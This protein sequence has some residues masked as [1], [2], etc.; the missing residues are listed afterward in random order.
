MKTLMTK[1]AVQA[2]RKMPNKVG[3]I[4]IN[5]VAKNIGL[6]DVMSARDNEVEFNLVSESGDCTITVKLSAA[7]YDELLAGILL[8]LKQEEPDFKRWITDF[9]KFRFPK[10][11]LWDKIN[12]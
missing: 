8:E 4:V 3:A 9:I 7:A 5:T 2:L 10:F 1:A 11:I 12:K 6:A